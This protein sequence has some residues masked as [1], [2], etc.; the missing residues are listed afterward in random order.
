MKILSVPGDVRTI[1]SV[2]E[3]FYV[4]SEL[5]IFAPRIYVLDPKAQIKSKLVAN[6]WWDHVLPS[7]WLPAGKAQASA[8]YSD[9]IQRYPYF[10]R[11]RPEFRF[12]ARDDDAPPT[13]DKFSTQQQFNYELGWGPNKVDYWVRDNWGNTFEHRAL[14]RGLPS[15]YA[16]G[17]APFLLSTLFVLSCF[18]LAPKV[19]FCHSAIMNPWLRKY[20]S[21]GS[22]PLLLSV[23]PS[24]R[25]HILS[26]Y[27]ANVRNQ[28]DFHDWQSRFIYPS[29]DFRPERFGNRLK[30]D[31]RLLLIGRSGIGKT[32][33]F[34]HLTAYYAS[35][36]DGIIPAKHFPVYISL[37]NYGGGSLEDLVLDQLFSYGSITD[38]ELAPLFLEQGG[39]VIFLDGVNEVRSVGDRQKLSVFVE[40]F[41]TINYICL[42]SQQGYPEIENIPQFELKP[43]DKATIC[44]FIRQRTTDKARA[45]AVI[46]RLNDQ[47]YQLYSVPRDLEFGV[48]ILNS[49]QNEMPKARNDLY[50]TV[51]KSIFDNW[52][53]NGNLDAENSLCQRAYTMIVERDLVFDSVET[54]KFREITSDLS[55]EKFLVRRENSYNFRHD[56]I[57]SY[58]ASEYFSPRWQI[59]LK[60][61]D[62][63]QIDSNWLEMLKFTCGDLINSL[64][65]RDLIFKVM[66]QSISKDLVKKLFEWLK[67]NHPDKCAEWETEFYARYG[68]LDFAG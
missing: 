19:R 16:F 42:S 63:P 45:E 64:E 48:E 28:S 33:F 37:T 12:A 59:L 65:I 58:L 17:G 32:S 9:E 4:V 14:Y 25:R 51:F 55:R 11:I 15:Q 49:G 27:L 21:L 56:L 68:K 54:P 18:G 36:S 3:F 10:N 1:V 38:K 57:R 29:E 41:W 67:D 44:E 40:K 30:K 61:K 66:T 6:N 8:A 34:K 62:E 35:Q 31:R 52:R 26:R 7:E 50:R 23:F 46:E 5:D 60:K 2:G 39:F 43:F 22:V 47:S 24:L 53:E 13:D 20:F